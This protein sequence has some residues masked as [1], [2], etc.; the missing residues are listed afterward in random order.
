MMGPAATPPPMP[1]AR[2]AVLSA[3]L[4]AA[5][6]VAAALAAGSAVTPAR[7]VP[8]LDLKPY[9]AAAVG[10]RRW[11]IQL[12]GVLKTSPDPALSSNPADWRVELIVGRELQLD[13][14]L[15]RLGG[16]LE[17]ESLK[18][19]GTTIYRVKDAGPLLF[20]RKACPPDQAKRQGFVVLGAKP[21][22]VP[23][24]ASLPI[25]IYAPRDLQVRWRL[26]KAERL[27]QPAQA[28]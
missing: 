22:V 19:S 18:G 12:P 5:L 4:P 9:P 26:W 23:Y 25:V 24:K 17:A 6:L 8:R 11:L 15:H 13:C 7:A 16:R 14:N 27:Q 20:T 3:A 10:E 28:L 21:Y 1:A 2:F